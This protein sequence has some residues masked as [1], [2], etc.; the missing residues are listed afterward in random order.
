MDTR[1]VER[2][3][4]IADAPEMCRIFIRNF[5]LQIVPRQT[6]IVCFLL[7]IELLAINE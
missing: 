3:L 7:A 1:K 2:A 6:I 4:R 5:W